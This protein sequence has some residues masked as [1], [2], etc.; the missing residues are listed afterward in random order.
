MERERFNSLVEQVGPRLAEELRASGNMYGAMYGAWMPMEP[1]KPPMIKHDGDPR[2]PWS[3]NC[4]LYGAETMGQVYPIEGGQW[5]SCPFPV[6]RGSEEARIFGTLPEAM[7]HVE[8]N[9]GR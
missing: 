7:A 8:A 5:E 6:R 9:G 4:G 1:I 3:W 2:V